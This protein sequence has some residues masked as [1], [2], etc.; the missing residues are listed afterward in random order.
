LKLET[1]LYRS[2]LITGVSSGIGHGL[3]KV[4]VSRGVHVWGISRRQPEDLKDNKKFSF[5]SQDLRDH[6]KTADTIEHL[7]AGVL[8][9][10]LVVLNAGMLGPIQ[11]MAATELREL[12]EVFE[13]NVWCNK[14]LLDALFSRSINI[15][16]VVSI[17]SG[18]SHK[19]SRGWGAYSLS[20]A[21]LNMLTKLYSA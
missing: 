11:D 9:L 3:A 14:V 13:I 12:K 8:E 19:G 16:Q 18:A 20:K 1:A 7:L 15:G 6:S 10:D 17:S 2:V 5:L 4:C 21:A